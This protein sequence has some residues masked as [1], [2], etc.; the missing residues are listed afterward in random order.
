MSKT[1]LRAAAVASSI[2]W[3]GLAPA[4]A[5]T[6]VGEAVSAVGSSTGVGGPLEFRTALQPLANGGNAIRYFIPLEN[7]GNFGAAGTCGSLGFGTC[8]DNGDG[9]GQLTMVLRFA[10]V[11]TTQSST[12]NLYFEDLDLANANDP[13][14]FFE[15]IRI[16]K[17]HNEPPA[18]ATAL[19]PWITDINQSV[20]G[21]T[22]QGDHYT[23]QV[24]QLALGTLTAA[25]EPLYIL[26]KFKSTSTFYGKN[27]PEYLIA[28]I[29]SQDPPC[30]T[31][32][33]PSC[34]STEVP[35]PGAVWL[36]GSVLFGAGGFVKWRQRRER[37]AQ[38]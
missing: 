5:L 16:F 25:Y 29:T 38:G 21:V 19:T 26:L 4:N 36:M 32:G 27:T 15:R 2:L 31:P 22:L 8:S 10:G 1:A 33:G 20:V 6:V 7:T 17:G 13:T 11:S 18:A 35:L 14:G 3:L 9:G 23:Q 34:G 30:G 12:L 28:T 37:R 24:L